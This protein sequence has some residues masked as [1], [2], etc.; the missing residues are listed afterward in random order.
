VTP[1]QVE[2]AIEVLEAALDVVLPAAGQP[3]LV[4]IA[5]ALGALAT[6]VT[7]AIAA[8]QAQQSPLAAEIGAANAVADAAEAAKFPKG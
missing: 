8:K 3:E 7:E 4:P 5:T 1:A 2:A 6:K